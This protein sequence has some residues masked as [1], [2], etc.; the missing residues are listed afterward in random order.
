[1]AG[2]VDDVDVVI[3]VLER[4]VLGLDGDA[5]FALEVHRIHDALGRRPG[6]S[7][8]CRIAGGA[9]DERGLAVVNVGNDGDVANFLDDFH[10]KGG[11][12]LAA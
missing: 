2:S 1:V 12:R 10:K 8:R 6:W 3:L 4:G 5:F 11:G 7:G 9:V